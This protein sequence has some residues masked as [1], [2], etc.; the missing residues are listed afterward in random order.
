MHS[1]IRCVIIYIIY[2]EI[3]HEYADIEIKDK[4][5]HLNLEDNFDQLEAVK[6]HSSSTRIV[7]T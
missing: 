7:S 6:L 1:S 2:E 3:L 4:Q 5:Y